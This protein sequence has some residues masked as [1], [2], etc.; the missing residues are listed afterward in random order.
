MQAAEALFVVLK[1]V[2]VD[3]DR[4][5]PELSVLAREALSQPLDHA[6]TLPLDLVRSATHAR[7]GGRAA[8]LGDADPR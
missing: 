7:E 6:N 8:R 5:N 1:L 3:D 4:L 2:A